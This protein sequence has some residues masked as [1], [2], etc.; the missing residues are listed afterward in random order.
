MRLNT[1]SRG[2]TLAEMAVV[3]VIVGLL[4]GGLLT[5]LSSQTELRLRSDNEKAL[6]DAREALIGFAIING[7]LPCPADRAIPTGNANAGVEATIAAGGP[8]RCTAAGSG[9]ASA[10]IVGVAC[11]DTGPNSVTGVMPWATLG[12]QETDAWNNRFTYRITTRFGRLAA[13]QTIF[14]CATP[15]TPNPPTNPANAAFALCSPGD[16]SIMA[17]SGATIASNLPAVVVSH[18][19]NGLGAWIPNGTQTGG[20]AGDELENADN[21]ATFVS[22]VSIDDQLIWLSPNLLMNR[23]IAAGKL[24]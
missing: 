13:N 7:R 2:F 20:A 22:D 21:D 23:M 11:N 4:L 12:L 10:S 16:I 24:P 9:L 18:G 15:P 17:T 3:L 8:C 19:K 14:G 5:P 1:F 6:A